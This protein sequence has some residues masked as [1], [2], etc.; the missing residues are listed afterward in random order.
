MYIVEVDD[1]NRE[2]A[3]TRHLLSH[4]GFRLDI[5][6]F[7]GL[8]EGSW[9]IME[10]QKPHLVP[11]L[12]GDVDILAGNLELR[13]PTN[14]SEGLKWP[15][16]SSRVVAVE[17]KCSY[18]SQSAGPQSEKD[19]PKKIKKLRGR[20]D[21]L[22]EMGF[23]KI[24]LLDVIGNEPTEGPGAFVSALG[25]A[26][27]SLRAFQPLIEARLGDD[28]AAAQFCWPVGSVFG[29]DEGIRGAGSLKLVR[30]GLENPLLAA[31][32]ESA[33]R[34]RETLVNNVS[35]MLADIPAPAY[36]PLFFIDCMDCDRLHFLHDASCLWKPEQ[37]AVPARD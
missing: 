21:L 29:G 8:G 16:I 11:G 12:F 2:K 14:V 7:M 24:G 37:R 1:N 15:P 31:G 4:L 35:R 28:T 36:W 23:D 22:Q 17:V 10:A 3:A 34:N 18:F 20:M 33:V 5:L 19:S 26:R 13:N 6:R 9:V 30:P 32:K 25:R 27:D